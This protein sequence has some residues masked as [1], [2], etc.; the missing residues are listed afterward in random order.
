HPPVL[1]I[2]K[3]AA[4]WIA[5]GFFSLSYLLYRASLYPQA[6]YGESFKS[7]FDTFEPQI[8]VQ[9]VMGRVFEITGHPETLNE[10]RRDQLQ[11]AW[12]YLQY[13]KVKCPVPACKFRYSM[14]PEEFEDHYKANHATQPDA[15]TAAPD[16]AAY[17]IELTAAYKD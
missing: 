9:R 3:T 14:S 17:R 12:R 10:G 8:D 7:V 15:V 6:Q 16:F 1:H 2:P 13:Y 4:W 11:I 5:M